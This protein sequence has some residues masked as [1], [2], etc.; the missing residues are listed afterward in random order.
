MLLDPGRQSQ[1]H[2]HLSP[3]LQGGFRLNND[4]QSQLQ[5]RMR[6]Q[7]A[8][9]PSN[10]TP[11]GIDPDVRRRSHHPQ[12]HV[13][14]SSVSVSGQPRDSS[15]TRQCIAGHVGQ[16][17]VDVY[18]VHL[19]A[20]AE[21]DGFLVEQPAQCRHEL[22]EHFGAGRTWVG[23]CVRVE[24]VED[25]LEEL[26]IA[27]YAVCQPRLRGASVKSCVFLSRRDET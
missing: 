25:V 11:N 15:A 26:T 27:A 19:G 3:A 8:S 12:P 22:G 23:G 2:A 4:S 16:G 10:H 6:A 14:V 17:G 20:R 7:P 24:M 18:A 5:S 9:R 1:L 13:E 21:E